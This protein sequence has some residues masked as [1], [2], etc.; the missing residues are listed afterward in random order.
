METVT[1]P[2]GDSETVPAP[3]DSHTP[4]VDSETVLQAAKQ[5]ISHKMRLLKLRN[6]DKTAASSSE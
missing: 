2:M 1:T 6:A 3:M 4:S 5:F